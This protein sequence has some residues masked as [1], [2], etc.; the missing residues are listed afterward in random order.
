MT[1]S[2]ERVTIGVLMRSLRQKLPAA[3]AVAAL[4]AAFFAA[5]APPAS[6]ALPTGPSV[7]GETGD[8]PG[9]TEVDFWI[10]DRVSASV[11][12]GTGN[13]RVQ[14]V[15]LSLPG[16]SEQVSIS[17][18]FNSLSTATGSTS[19]PAAAGWT[20]GFQ[21]MGNL[22]AG[23]SGVVIYTGADGATW[24]FTP[25]S[26]TPGA[27]T[28]PAG[29]KADLVASGSTFTLTFRQ[30]RT[31]ATFNSDGQPVSVA[32]RNGN[33]T[34][35]SYTS[36]KP[37]SITS[38]AGPVA[39][40]TA[41]MTYSSSTYKFTTTQTSGTASRSVE[42]VKNASS[43][44]VKITDATGKDT[45]FGYTSGK[46]TS[47]TAPGGAVITIGYVS[48]TSKVASVSRANTTAGSPGTSVTRFAYPSA[49]QTLLARPNTNQSAA[50]STVPRI[51]YTI[52]STS[53]L[54]TNAVDEMGRVQ[55]ATYTPN[56]DIATAT[57]GSGSTAG[58][59]TSTYG[60]NSGDSLTSVQSP[61]GATSSAAYANTGAATQYLPSS[62]T[63]ARGNTSTVTYNGS[64]NPVTSTNAL[65][66]TA[67]LSYNSR[68]QVS[69]ATAPGNGTNATSY[70]YN[71]TF[72]LSSMTPVTGSSLGARSMTYDSFGRLKT[73]TDGNGVT[74]T[75]SYDEADR[76]VS[77]SFSDA[78][79][80]V[81]YT[82]T[83]TG[84]PKTR[85][86]AHGTTTWGYD[87]L[88][89][90][91][92]RVNTY[93]GGTISYSYD[94][95]SNLTSATDSGGT[96]SYSFD[97]SGVPTKLTYPDGSGT[98]EVVFVTDDQGRRTDTYL[99]PTTGLV[100]YMGHTEQQY[101]RSGRVSRSIATTSSSGAYSV[102]F[103]TSYCYN[104]AGTAPTCSTATGTDTD[105]L[106]WERNNLTGQLTRYAYD[107]AGRLTS[108]TQTGGT[109][110]TTW[111]YTYDA[112]GNRTTAAAT[113]GVSSSQ[114]LTFNAGNQITS[115]GYAYDGAGNL[116]ASPSGAPGT[117]TYNGAQQMTS[118]TVGA[119]TLDY[120]YAGTSQVEVLK[121]QLP[122]AT[123]RL[124]YGRTDQHGNPVI[125][126]ARFDTEKAYIDNDPVTGQPL[127][128][129]TTGSVSLYVYS[130]TGNP[131]ANLRDSGGTGYTLTYDPYGLPALTSCDDCNEELLQNPFLFKGGIQDMGAGLFKFGNRWYNPTIG[132]WTQQDTL[133]APLDPANANR[134][135]YAG[136]DPINN[137]DPTGLFLSEAECAYLPAASIAFGAI[138]LAAI[139]I[140]PALSGIAGAVS[141]S[142]AVLEQL[143]C[144]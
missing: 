56:G 83:H 55:A 91:I 26:G 104:T 137:T 67:T 96:V 90:L 31:V 54:V 40:R 60:A 10:S 58:T 139:P 84:L 118:A 106:Q 50:V 115:S 66:A 24:S 70:G 85:V 3:L 37:T 124:V 59:T 132:T 103:D 6:A 78:T 76:V 51:T 81:T 69:T 32:D 19:T 77:T 52:N 126:Q 48:G 131:I 29:L 120:K 105:K 28:A 23:T 36:G 133:D 82:Y 92:T 88:G 30:S 64:G 72:Q 113:G 20:L 42:Y 75:H 98:K 79:P 16:V 144:D 87:Q 1:G 4:S 63:D 128:L 62:F 12:V 141:L 39:A 45:L 142:L 140:S 53:H 122:D 68:G 100:D 143:G 112:R 80:T 127:L 61:T 21:G 102:V 109:S 46:L 71:S 13:L 43:E 47:I 74:T 125:E 8:R 86:D 111:T 17:Q 15:G 93:A 107:S 130:G 121:R 35:I 41:A 89:R 18:T 27:Y 108:A 65:A 134:Y 11:D 9:G 110:P 38:T 119:D 138:G 22:S 123:L 99:N 97:D 95:S 57:S 33:T 136:A 7:V 5:V 49:T 135:A 34:T 14:T 94:K 2:R 117:Y 25:V 44:L 73:E 114:T 129:R 101:D 116:T